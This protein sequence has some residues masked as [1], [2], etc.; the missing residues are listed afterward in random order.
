MDAGDDPRLLALS[1]SDNVCVACS[2][3][4]AGERPRV[5][6]VEMPIAEAIMLGHKVARRDIRAGSAIL[7]YGAKVGVATAD[8]RRGGHVHVHN[9]RSDYLP[10]YT[11]D[12][13]NPYLG[14]DG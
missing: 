14:R 9:M 10:T 1:P 8:I 5:D 11:L 6:G 4:A 12:G 3:L 2:R 13:A 7:K